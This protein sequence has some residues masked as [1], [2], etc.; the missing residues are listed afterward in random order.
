MSKKI[1]ERF[2]LTLVSRRYP[3]QIGGAERVMQ[4]LAHGFAA[5]GLRV[6]VLSSENR[7]EGVE[8]TVDDRPAD[9][10]QNPKI[11][12]L[13]Y[14]GI[15]MAGT[16]F[17]LRALERWFEKYRPSLVYVSML[18][19]D[20]F[21]SVRYGM[22]RGVP[23]VLR[24]EG[25]GL[26]GD[27]GWQSQDR[28]GRVIAR[29]T[30]QANAFVALSPRI[31]DEL[32]EAGYSEQRIHDIPNGVPIPA[33]FW[34]P[35]KLGRGPTAA[36]VGRLA[37]EK[38]LDRLLRAWKL[39]HME[40]PEARLE[41]IGE[42]PSEESLRSM[43][44]ASGIAHKVDFPGARGDIAQCLAKADLFVLPSR[45]EGLSMSLLEAMAAGIPVVVSDIPGNRTLVKQGE[46]GRIVNCE[47]TAEFAQ[48]ILA[49]LRGDESTLR[50]AVD[51]RSLVSRRFSIEFMVG[52]H[53]NLFRRLNHE[54]FLT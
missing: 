17:Y 49:G 6:T 53:L 33:H 27:M 8:R 36:F 52:E 22:R 20:A 48:A 54:R 32:L 30:R 37:P 24:P 23:I 21:S 9:D 34:T 28:F 3:P 40:L 45:E 35:P 26:T 50:M 31:H 10:S 46:T 11:V 43:A 13:P 39:V 25:A 47:N 12:R 2:D 7:Q 42:G 15:R 51:G 18:K 29:T 16:F 4:N 38:G 14:S 41:I 1:E 5:Q 19:H 44:T